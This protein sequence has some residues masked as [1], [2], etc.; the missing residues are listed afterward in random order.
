[1]GFLLIFASGLSWYGWNYVQAFV[2]Y[3][4]TNQEYFLSFS[5]IFLLVEMTN[6]AVIDFTVATCLYLFTHIITL[7]GFREYAVVDPLNY[8]FPFNAR[9]IFHLVLFSTFSLLH[10]FG[11][12]TFCMY[13]FQRYKRIVFCVSLNVVICCLFLTHIRYFFHLIP[14]SLLGCSLFLD[15]KIFKRK[16]LK[17]N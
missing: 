5:N 16:A 10:T 12:I 4:L 9:S 6:I 3:S 2:D 15:K 13:F 1:M 7:T 14:L 17:D 11:I 8:F